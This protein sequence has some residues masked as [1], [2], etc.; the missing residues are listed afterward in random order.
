MDALRNVRHR[1]QVVVT[2]YRGVSVPCGGRF[3]LLR[4]VEVKAAVLINLS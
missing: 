4:A 1:T 3:G 2:A